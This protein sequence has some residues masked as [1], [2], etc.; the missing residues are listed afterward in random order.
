M[1]DLGRLVKETFKMQTKS[2]GGSPFQA[3]EPASKVYP[4]GPGILYRIE[5]SASTFRVHTIP[6]KNLAKDWEKM[7]VGDCEFKSQQDPPV[8]SLD[9]IDFFECQYFEIAEVIS[10]LVGQTRYPLYE[11]DFYNLGDPGHSWWMKVDDESLILYFKKS[12]YSDDN[13]IVKLGPI[14]DPSLAERRFS[15]SREF[16]CSFINVLE[17]EC[18]DSRIELKFSPES[19]YNAHLF[20]RLLTEGN[21][22]IYNQL[23]ASFSLSGTLDYFFRELISCRKFW[24]EVE[25]VIYKS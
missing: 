6:S 12:R 20:S 16:F 2:H 24:I 3:D 14:G 17:F 5:K 1:D 19:S 11:E 8:F 4:E 21:V 13:S 9:E 7:K 23:Q 25:K 15:Q 18:N 22:Q 10:E